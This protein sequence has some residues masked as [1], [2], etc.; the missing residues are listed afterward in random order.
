MKPSFDLPN[1]RVAE[2]RLLVLTRRF[3][4]QTLLVIQKNLK[5]CRIIQ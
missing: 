1:P 3:T 2:L 5:H 4:Q